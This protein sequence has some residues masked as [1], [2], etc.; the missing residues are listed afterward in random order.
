ML[1]GGENVVLSGHT[2]TFMGARS[3]FRHSY[4]AVEV[5]W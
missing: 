3:V 2:G 1:I 5:W 4:E